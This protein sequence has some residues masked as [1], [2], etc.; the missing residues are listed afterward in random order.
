[1]ATLKVTGGTGG[2]TFTLRVTGLQTSYS[3]NRYFS[4]NY[5]YTT[6][7]AKASSWSAWVWMGYT[8]MSPG[9]S[10]HT[11]SPLANDFNDGY[12]YCFEVVIYGGDSWSSSTKLATLSQWDYDEGKPSEFS[13]FKKKSVVV[14]NI[15]SFTATQTKLGEKK[16]FCDWDGDGLNG[17]AV[18]SARQSGTS[19]WYEKAKVSSDKYGGTY[20]ATVDSFATYEF[21]VYVVNDD[22]YN[23]AE[24]VT[25]VVV[26]D[27]TGGSDADAPTFSTFT[28]S[29]VGTS[30]KVDLYWS[31]SNMKG[32]DYTVF[33]YTSTGGLDVIATG[34]MTSNSRT[35]T[36]SVDYYDKEYRFHVLVG[37]RDSDFRYLT[38]TTS[39]SGS[40]T[41]SGTGTGKVTLTVTQVYLGSSDF[42]WTASAPDCPNYSVYF[43]TARSNQSFSSQW[44]IAAELNSN[45]YITGRLSGYTLG[46]TYKAYVNIYDP[47]TGTSIDS[48]VVYFTLYEKVDRPSDFAWTYAKTKGG[49]F[50][51]TAYEWKDL[52]YCINQFRAYKGMADYTFSPTRNDIQSG[53]TF[54]ATIYNQARDAIQTISGCGYTSSAV[55]TGDIVTAACLNNLVTDLNTIP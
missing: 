53:G 44:D 2:D 18:I 39:G 17:T 7:P 27:S 29:Q 47:S 4:W 24:T 35:V 33:A 23:D 37:S 40:G 51:L 19:Y 52:M 41:G 30:L 26:A 22:G 38:L 48:D 43:Y 21:K 5:S 8:S 32:K 36:V 54:T 9:G 55:S 49:A 13:I 6:T 10:S 11:Y 50:N 3:Y 28:A 46:Y 14:A 16:V 34:T 15:T 12:Y 42:Y 1:M 31:G 20:T 45:G 25:G